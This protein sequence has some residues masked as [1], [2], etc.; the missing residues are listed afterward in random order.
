MENASKALLMASG[1]LIAVLTIGFLVYMFTNSTSFFRTSDDVKNI[2]QIVAFNREYEA[3]NRKL[4][5]GT[6]VISIMNKASNNNIIY[7][8]E[9][10]R[11]IIITFELVESLGYGKDE[12]NNV[13]KNSDILKVGK[14]YSQEDQNWIN[15]KKNNEAF[16]D[17]K[18]RVFNCMQTQYDTETG[19]ISKMT[20]KEQKIDYT[21]GL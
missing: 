15:L 10:Q 5:R 19:R 2:E 20:F 7:Q 4:L 18:R 1:I 12:D 11:K 8:D 16:T 3:Y 14:T 9:P 17:F 21:E 6:D 13:I